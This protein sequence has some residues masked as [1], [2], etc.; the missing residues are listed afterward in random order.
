MINIYLF[1]TFFFV[2]MESEVCL[3]SVEISDSDLSSLHHAEV[4]E[5]TGYTE[6]TPN[7]CENSKTAGHTL[8]AEAG[9]DALCLNTDIVTDQITNV[10][11]S[12]QYQQKINN[13]NPIVV[14]M[15]GG[16]GT[17]PVEN[18]FQ[19]DNELG[20]GSYIIL[21]GDAAGIAS[22]TIHFDKNIYHPTLP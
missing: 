19:M 20:D 6:I 11:K 13:A 4:L 18:V 7:E 15:D 9:E 5:V 10:V 2:S 8:T 22:Q 16:K 12:N 21:S 14:Q 3:P 17:I 1:K